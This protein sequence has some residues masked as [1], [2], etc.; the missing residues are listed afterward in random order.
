MP[1]ADK[2]KDVIDI[3]FVSKIAFEGFASETTFDTTKN[4]LA[5]LIIINV[6]DPLAMQQGSCY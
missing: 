6:I 3:V 1:L 2:K 5:G 4:L